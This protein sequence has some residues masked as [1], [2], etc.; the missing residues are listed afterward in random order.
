M[1]QQ[2]L[3]AVDGLDHVGARHALHRQNDRGVEVGPRADQ[4]VLRALDCLA[5]IADTHRRAVSVGENQVVVGVRLDELIVG[6]ESP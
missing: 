4:V 6:V 2:R 5:D 3:D 1:R